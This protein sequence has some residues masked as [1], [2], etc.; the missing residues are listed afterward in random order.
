MILF[1][2]LNHAAAF[3]ARVERADGPVHVPATRHAQ[4]DITL[5]EI[6]EPFADHLEAPYVKCARGAGEPSEAVPRTI[7]VAH[8]GLLHL[9]EED[10]WQE[11]ANER[12]Q[13]AVAWET[14]SKF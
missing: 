8:A 2:A 12:G 14:E 9:G 7:D 4:P 3:P 5:R 10:D 6:L 11:H 13:R 1:L